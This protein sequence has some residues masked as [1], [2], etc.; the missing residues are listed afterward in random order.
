VQAPGI[1]RTLANETTMSIKNLTQH[2]PT[3]EQYDGNGGVTG[4]DEDV[5]ELLN[6]ATPP[7]IEEIHARAVALAALAVGFEFAMIGGAPYLMGPLVA[8]LKAAGVQP[9]FSFTERKSLEKLNPDGSVVKTSVFAH[10][11]WVAV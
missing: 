11:A 3:Q 5:V 7:S 9:I 10:V 8:A 4:V 1:T 6:F 2:K